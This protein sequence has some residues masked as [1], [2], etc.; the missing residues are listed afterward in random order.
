MHIE[1]HAPGRI[2]LLGSGETSLAGGRVFE[3]LARVLPTPLRVAVLETP[4]GFELNS[5]RVAGRVADFLAVRLGNYR[6]DITVVPARQRGTHFSPDDPTITGP[7]LRADLLFMGPGS[8]TYAVRQLRDSLAWRRLI[9]R[10]RIGATVA[11]ASATV[12]AISAYA[13]PVYEIYKAGH[14]LYWQPGLDLFGPYG[15]NLVFV[16][17][18][19]NTEGGAELDTSRC[20]M[21]RSRFEKLL[22]M[23]PPDATVVGID[24]HTAL[25]I[26]LADGAAEV[27]G[28]GDVTV[29]HGPQVQTFSQGGRFSLAEFGPFA[30]PEPDAGLPPEIWAEAL[31]AHEADEGAAQ[32]PAE[33]LTLVEERQAARDRRDWGAADALRVRIEALGWQVQDR[34]GDPA[35]APKR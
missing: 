5:D 30:W 23:L 18:W 35:L 13:L 17:H 32:P 1:G 11:F 12:V 27:M 19:N 29:L 3:S 21:G 10:Q 16:P 15:L 31:A 14:D 34:P 4:A 2:A 26:D 24:E 20:F 28:A 8:P 6:P 33:V 25:A 22:A 9:A 7:L